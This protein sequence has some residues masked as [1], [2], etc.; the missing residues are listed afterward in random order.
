MGVRCIEVEGALDEKTKLPQFNA[1]CVQHAVREI[2]ASVAD[3]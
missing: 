1:S 3:E 2:L